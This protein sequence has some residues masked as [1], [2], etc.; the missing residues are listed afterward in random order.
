MFYLMMHSTHCI[1]G[2]MVSEDCTSVCFLFHFHMLLSRRAMATSNSVYRSITSAFCYLFHFH[3]SSGRAMTTSNSVY[4]SI[5]SDF[6]YLFHF[7]MLLSRRVMATSNSVY[8]SIT[9][10]FCYLF[11]FHMSSRRAM[12]T[13]NSVYRSITSDFCSTFKCCHLEGSWLPPIVKNVCKY[14]QL[15]VRLVRFLLPKK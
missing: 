8:R 5:T 7:H 6:C 15:T 3:M 2:Y 13:S 14:M 12:A 4:R 9:S 10:D 11:H 1:Y